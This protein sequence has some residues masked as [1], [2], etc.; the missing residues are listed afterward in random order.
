VATIRPPTH[1]RPPVRPGTPPRGRGD[2]AA[3][4]LFAAL[5]AAVSVLLFVV[6][7]V[8]ALGSMDLDEGG[9]AAAERLASL[10]VVLAATAGVAAIACATHGVRLRRQA[11]DNHGPVGTPALALGVLA[12]LLSAT[13]TVFPGGI[14]GLVALATG[15]PAWIDGHR[16]GAA[17]TTRA[18]VG[19]LCGAMAVMIGLWVYFAS[20]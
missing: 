15:I 8:E 1:E 7:F 11:G 13:L 14:L 5:L 16:R 9:V 2:P 18:V 10:L 17:G 6:G 3:W 12:L 20:W 4:T 19:T